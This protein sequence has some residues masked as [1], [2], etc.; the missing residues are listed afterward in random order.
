[1]HFIASGKKLHSHRSATGLLIIF[2]CTLFEV[3]QPLIVDHHDTSSRV[4]IVDDEQDTCLLLTTY[5]KRMGID[6]LA[7]YSINAALETIPRFRPNVILLD[8]NLPDG[9]GWQHTAS[10]IS[11]AP[12]SRIFLMSAYEHDERSVL[13]NHRIYH[14]EKPISL[15]AL[16][17]IL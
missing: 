2:V 1:M 9:L 11:L 17:H 14:L 13:K 8:N 16:K 4:L 15:S 12:E 3:I 10:M 5:L 7:V 6:A